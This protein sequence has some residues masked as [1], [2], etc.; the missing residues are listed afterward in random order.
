[1]VEPKTIEDIFRNLDTYLDQLLV[2]RKFHAIS[3]Y[4]LDYK[5]IVRSFPPLLY[6]IWLF[7]LISCSFLT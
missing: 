7:K 5:I 3:L 4:L 2:F 1:M 6:H